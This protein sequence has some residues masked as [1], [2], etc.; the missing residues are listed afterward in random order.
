M[1]TK[2][3]RYFTLP[4]HAWFGPDGREVIYKSRRLIPRETGRE[5]G[6]TVVAQS[7]RLDLVAFRTL[8]QPDQFWRLC[9]L[10]RAMNPFD[11]VEPSGQTLRVPEV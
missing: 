9:D 4:D 2:S 8:A 5:G 1:F 10:N 3:S 11:L 7:E 6:M